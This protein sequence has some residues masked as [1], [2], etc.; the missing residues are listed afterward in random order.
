M[1]GDNVIND[2]DFYPDGYNNIPEITMN[3]ESGISWKDFDFSF[4]F[5]EQHE[6]MFIIPFQHLPVIAESRNG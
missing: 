3:L 1:N 6:E 4:L 2:N 5:Q